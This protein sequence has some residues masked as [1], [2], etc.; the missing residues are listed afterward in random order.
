MRRG[1]REEKKLTPRRALY[2]CNVPE[3]LDGN[4][5]KMRV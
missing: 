4:V 3:E 5:D 2:V 1:S